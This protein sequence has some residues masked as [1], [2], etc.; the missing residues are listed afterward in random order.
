MTYQVVATPGAGLLESVDYDPSD[1]AEIERLNRRG[2][3]GSVF[4]D[5]GST[6]DERERDL[7]SSELDGSTYS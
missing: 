5:T 6:L 1:E 4:P 2:Y 3:D 7:I